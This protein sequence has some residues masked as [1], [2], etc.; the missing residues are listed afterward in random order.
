MFLIVVKCPVSGVSMLL[1]VFT[2]YKKLWILDKVYDPRPQ[3][4]EFLR[5]EPQ[6]MCTDRWGC[7]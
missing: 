7:A 6:G 2:W 5:T 4:Y 1:T 3:T